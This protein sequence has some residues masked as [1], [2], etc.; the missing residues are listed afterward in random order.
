M[1]RR[2]CCSKKY[3]EDVSMTWPSH[4]FPPCKDSLQ[5]VVFH[6]P[7]GQSYGISSSHTW[8]WEL[9]HKEGWAPKNW[10][11]Q[12]VVL[13]KTLENPL[14]SK[15][16]KPVN[17]KGNQSWIS[18]RRTDAEA[19]API[20]GPSDAKSR[21]IWKDFDPGKDWGREEKGLQRMRWLDGITDSMDMSLRKLREIVKDREAWCAAVHGVA[22]SWTGLSDWTTTI[23]NSVI[24][25]NQ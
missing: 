18:I 25:C 8:M 1:R 9:D 19:E 12:T 24:I 3:P 2:S 16:I 4:S 5:I 22:R 20:L 11:F 13:E 14:D 10:C 7:Y 6:G 23:Y 21:L 17:P 15:E